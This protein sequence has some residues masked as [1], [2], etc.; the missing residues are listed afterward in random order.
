MPSGSR[1]I[2]RFGDSYGHGQRLH[3]CAHQPRQ[4]TGR[5]RRL[6]P[7]ML[8]CSAAIFLSL[9]LHGGESVALNAADP[10]IYNL[11]ETIE[12]DSWDAWMPTATRN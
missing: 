3:C 5:S 7:A 10:N 11:A 9:D 8:I 6:F 2:A 4:S 1:T 12:P